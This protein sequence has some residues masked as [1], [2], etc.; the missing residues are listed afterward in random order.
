MDVLLLILRARII[1]SRGLKEIRSFLKRRNASIPKSLP[2]E[3]K[4][5]QKITSVE[6][7][8]TTMLKK[9]LSL[10][11]KIRLFNSI[12]GTQLPVLLYS[13]S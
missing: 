6:V 2:N 3:L 13:L 12:P 4:K 7:S 11:S 1:S 8:D 10:A 5:V 9:D